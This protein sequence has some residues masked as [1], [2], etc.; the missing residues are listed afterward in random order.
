METVLKNGLSRGLCDGASVVIANPVPYQASLGSIMEECN[1]WHTVRDAVWATL[2]N[3]G[4][5]REDFRDRLR[6]Y[7]PNIVIDACTS[8]RSRH[9]VYSMNAHVAI[10][11]A[12][13]C[14]EAMLYASTHPSSWFKPENRWSKRVSSSTR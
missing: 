12:A 3:I 13:H 1:D 11:V 5:V 8:G 6:H 9:P 4:A 2:W 14:S 7:N 10:S